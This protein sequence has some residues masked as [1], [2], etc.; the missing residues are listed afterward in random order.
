MMNWIFCGL[1]REFVKI[2]QNMKRLREVRKQ[3]YFQSGICGPFSFTKNKKFR[4]IIILGV[5]L[6]LVPSKSPLH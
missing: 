2:Y 3:K 4:F 1:V 5:R 6:D